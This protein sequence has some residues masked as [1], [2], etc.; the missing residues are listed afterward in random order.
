[1]IGDRWVGSDSCLLLPGV[2][3]NAGGAVYGG[4]F[5][6]RAFTLVLVRVMKSDEEDAVN[7]LN[8]SHISLFFI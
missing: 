8:F 1:M 5:L 4:I 3:V 7:V 2:N 6:L